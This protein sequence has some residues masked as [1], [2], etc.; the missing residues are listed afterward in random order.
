MDNNRNLFT[1]HGLHLNKLGKQ[2]VINHQIASLLLITSEQ[3]TSSRIILE[4]HEIQDDNNQT[5]NGNQVKPSN[6]NHQ[7]G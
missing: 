3:E 4:W 5:C 1:N 7:P 2:L 6:N